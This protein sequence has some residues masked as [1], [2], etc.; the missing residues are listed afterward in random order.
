MM[1]KLKLKL[2]YLLACCCGLLASL[3]LLPLYA[4]ASSQVDFN[5][6]VGISGGPAITRLEGKAASFANGGSTVVLG[7]EASG[8]QGGIFIDSGTMEP[9]EGGRSGRLLPTG[10]RSESQG[11]GLR[12]GYRFG[13]LSGYGEIGSSRRSFY[14]STEDHYNEEIKT[15]HL[16]APLIGAG[17]T[18]D[19]YAGEGFRFGV[20]AGLRQVDATQARLDPRGNFSQIYEQQY[21]I[22]FTMIPTRWV[23]PRYEPRPTVICFDCASFITRVGVE[24][25][26]HI[27]PELGKSLTQAVFKIMSN[28]R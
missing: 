18:Y 1:I 9:L 6:Q 10:Y 3:A 11:I 23:L 21:G 12:L 19:I 17:F 15:R 16:S 24:A 28:Y 26:V 4:S 25:G 20:Q 14:Q 27:L 13:R 2:K 7:I 5:M 8:F 22:V